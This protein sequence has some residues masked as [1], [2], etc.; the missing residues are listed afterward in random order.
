MAYNWIEI[1]ATGTSLGLN[2]ADDDHYYPI[3]L[4]FPVNFY[5]TDYTDLAVATNGTVYFEDNYLGYDNTPI[6]AVNSDGVNTYIALLWT[7]LDVVPGE[8]Y[9]EVQGTAPHRRVVI[10]YYQV[11]HCCT[12]PDA[13]SWEIIL[14]EDQPDI[15]MQ[16]QDVNFGDAAYDYGANVTVGIQNSIDQGVEYS[17]NSPVLTDSLAIMFAPLPA[18]GFAADLTFAVTTTAPVP[19]GTWITNT[20]IVSDS[21]GDAWS[22][23]AATL[24]SNPADLSIVKQAPASVSGLAPLTYTLSITNSGPLAA[25]FVTVTDNLPA[26][27]TFIGASG[28]GWSCSQLGET[29]TCAQASLGVGAASDIVIDVTAPNISGTLINT[30]LVAS[31]AYD[32]GQLN[33]TATATTTVTLNTRSLITATTGT[34]SGTIDLTPPGGTYPYGIVVT[35]TATANVGSTFTGWSGA[36]T[37]TGTCLVTMDDDKSITAT[38]ALNTYTLT[39]ATVGNGSVTPTTSVYAY[40]TVVPVTAT[41]GVGS[42]FAGWSGDLSGSVNPTSI[43]ID[44]DK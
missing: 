26:G 43:L 4:P 35:A 16:Y 20:A 12:S 9:Y 7:D 33:N 5:G 6:P 34:G 13:G 19:D 17:Y 27:V 18:S 21:Y 10:E 28:A 31:T 38:F 37:G 15:L 1:S 23:S 39:V 44:G 11:S 36:C 14:Y 40:G 30:A 42:S 22:L 41:A 29:V 3:A 32:E 24:L 25:A 8:I 2:G